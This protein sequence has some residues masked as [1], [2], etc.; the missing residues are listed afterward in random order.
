[1]KAKVIGRIVATLLFI[2][3]CA[4]SRSPGAAAETVLTKGTYHISAVVLSFTQSTGN[5]CFPVTIDAS[6]KYIVSMYLTYNGPGKAAQA[7]LEVPYNNPSSVTNSEAVILFILSE[8]PAVGD[9]QWNGL[10]TEVLEQNGQGY[11]TYALSGTLVVTSPLSL[12]GI[13]TLSG[14]VP[15]NGDLCTNVSLQ[16]SGVFVGPPLPAFPPP[17]ITPPLVTTSPVITPAVRN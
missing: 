16:Y 8:T 3:V 11:F 15:G 2:G 9:T 12:D 14:V 7:T 4:V 13:I 5:F 10:Y 6:G 1:M 17:P